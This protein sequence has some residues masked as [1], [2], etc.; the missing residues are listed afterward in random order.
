LDTW[1]S[2]LSRTIQKEE[3]MSEVCFYCRK[4]DGEIRRWKIGGITVDA[5][6][7][8]P[9]KEL[10]GHTFC[11][12]RY[13]L[14]LI[15]PLFLILAGVGITVAGLSA[16]GGKD[17]PAY[18]YWFWVVVSIIVIRWRILFRRLNRRLV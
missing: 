9:I 16:T 18:L 4:A 6:L 13:R 15:A 10:Y 2:V 1:E 8:D 11:R 12:W 14:F 5:L 17:V 3:A 7:C